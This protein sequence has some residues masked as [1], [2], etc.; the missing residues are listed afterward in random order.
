MT[1]THK[2]SKQDPATQDQESHERNGVQIRLIANNMED[3]QSGIV[4]LKQK[5]NPK[6]LIWIGRSRKGSKGDYLAYAMIIPD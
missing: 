5:V 6:N 1:D 4:L 2:G 3:L